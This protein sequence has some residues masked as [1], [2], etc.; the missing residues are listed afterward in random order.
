VSLSVEEILKATEGRLVQGKRGV[1]FEGVSTDSRTIREKELFIALRGNRF[2][3]HTYALEALDRRA[4][5]VLIE[6]TRVGDFRWNGYR[7]QAV[8]A[9]RD[10]L[11]ALGDLARARRRKYG[12]PLVAITGSNG[13]T[14]TKEMVAG[15]LGTRLPILKTKGNFNNL[16]G[17]PLTLLNLTE[18]EKV[19]VL[20]LGMNVLG[21]IRRLTEIAEPDIGLI[22]NIQ[23]VHLEGMGSLER[24]TKEKGE[25][26]RGVKRDGVIVVNRDDPR[27]V[28]LAKEFPGQK[29]T[30]GVEGRADVE[31]KKIELTRTGTSFRL[32]AGDEE[33][34]VVLQAF[35]RH[36]VMNAL[37][38]V[39]VASL[40]KIDLNDVK[41][42]L[43]QFRPYAMRMEII[44]LPVGKTLI[45]DT[46]NANPVSM[47]LA[48]EVLVAMKGK[49][50]AIALLGDMLELG[51]FSEEAHRQLGK[52]ISEL[53]I[54]F[55]IMLGERG[56]LVVESAVHH[57]FPAEKVRRVKDHSEALLALN[58][59]AR[60][61][62]WILI[63]G[64]RGMAM[65]KIAERLKEGRA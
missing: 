30:F 60:E 15:C 41:A 11:Q 45:N 17:L 31:A 4:A 65:E 34:E 26:F 25:L 48:L 23:M 62:D 43:E 20:E 10:S 22:T 55:I 38:A 18:K 28:E 14:T 33:T 53:P 42:A 39:A 35:G 40:F 29:I 21:E 61:G 50:R 9:V 7:S 56:A 59:V 58:E 12:T 44:P 13:K 6:E 16:I 54:D 27:V 24:L 46:Y 64:S 32:V 57:G 36:F 51:H 63:K 8:I 47:G 3:G 2:D 1:F 37:S 19:V 49:G 52:K 5:G